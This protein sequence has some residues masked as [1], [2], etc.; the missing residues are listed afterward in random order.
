MTRRAFSEGDAYHIMVRGV[1]R[2]IIFEDDCDRQRFCDLLSS[3]VEQTRGDG[4]EVSLLAWCLM[5]NHVHLL[6]RAD[7]LSLSPL[8]RATL[9]QYARYFNYRH[10]RVGTL[11]QGRFK[12][13]PIK[14]D[15]Q[16]LT[17]LRYIHHNPLEIGRPIQYRWSSYREYL[18]GRGMADVEFCLDVMGGLEQFRRFHEP[19]ANAAHGTAK[20]EGGVAA[21]CSSGMWR[22]PF[23]RCCTPMSPRISPSWKSPLAMSSWQGSGTP[24]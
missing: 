24:D 3:S 4:I 22:R 13:V 19:D 8:L 11:F 12:S 9:S 7:L 10:D 1:G 23:G 15:A 18:R 5:Q 16:L 20:C 6:F 2:Q 14:D 17:V 21:A